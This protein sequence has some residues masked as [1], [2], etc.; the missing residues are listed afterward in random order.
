MKTTNTKGK[1]EASGYMRSDEA[2]RYLGICQRTLKDW[3]RRRVIPF[4]K[5]SKGCCLFKR[6]ELDA[7]LGRFRVEAAG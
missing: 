4:I 5:P 2:A 7:A 3:Q 1:T 6:T